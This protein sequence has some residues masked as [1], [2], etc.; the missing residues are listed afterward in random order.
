MELLFLRQN[1]S[2]KIGFDQ[3]AGTKQRFLLPFPH[4]EPKCTIIKAIISHLSWGMHL[5]SSVREL[6]EISELLHQRTKPQ[7]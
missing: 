1:K 7:K 4:L 3:S 5:T 2:L 6:A